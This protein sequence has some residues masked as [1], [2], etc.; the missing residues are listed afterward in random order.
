MRVQALIGW[1]PLRKYSYL[2]GQFSQASSPVNSQIPIL[3]KFEGT[4]KPFGGWSL[5]IS[6]MMFDQMGEAPVIPEATRLMGEPSLLPTQVAT[7]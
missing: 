5:I 7:R 3:I 4:S 2:V 1:V 6:L